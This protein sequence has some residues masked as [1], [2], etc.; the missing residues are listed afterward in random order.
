MPRYLLRVEAVNLNAFV[1]D[2]YDISTIR[3]GS[4]ILLQAIKELGKSTEF[5]N[6]LHLISNGASQG[7]FW[8]L[9]NANDQRA[10]DDIQRDV[11]E[12]LAD[13]TEHHAT[14]V[15]AVQEDRPDDF[16][17][18]L[19]R[20]E[21]QIRRRQWRMPTVAV[22]A[23]GQSDQECYIDGWRPGVVP[24]RLDPNIHDAAISAATWFRRNTGRDLKNTLFHRLLGEDKYADTLS[25]NDLEQLANDPDR[26]VLSGKI[27]LIHLDGNGFGGIRDRQCTTP[28]LRSEFDESYQKGFREREFLVSLL[29]LADTDLLFQNARQGLKPVLRIEVLLWGGDEMTLIVP[30]WRGW[31][32]LE[33]FFQKAQGRAFHGEPLTHRAVIVFCHHNAPILQ[34]RRLAEELL[35]RTKNEIKPHPRDAIHYLAL[36]SFDMLQGSLDHFIRE[37]YGGADY[38]TL[39]LDPQALGAISEN[40]KTI[41]RKIARSK[42]I[43]IVKAIQQKDPKRVNEIIKRALDS[44]PGQERPNVEAAI[45]ALTGQQIEHWYWVADL[46]DYI[47]EWTAP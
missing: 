8:F 40:A 35:D 17:G 46:W 20:L 15:T 27:A 11:L 45:A 18:V 31:Q 34:I 32:A 25:A 36:E 1:F 13:K 6:R 30:A 2:T 9:A 12:W 47:P 33:L 39:L 16:A 10:L 44:V 42:V 3:G 38:R 28:E 22:P 29:K 4:F 24:Y 21:A 19:R 7:L 23:A 14:F 26:G 41:H 5:E 37:Y 43:E